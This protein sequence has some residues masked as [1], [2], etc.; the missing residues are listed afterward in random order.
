MIQILL[1][2]VFKSGIRL[3]ENSMKY[4]LIMF[5]KPCDVPRYRCSIA[6]RISFSVI[7]SSSSSNTVL[8]T[9]GPI[10]WITS[11]EFANPLTCSMEVSF[12]IIVCFGCACLVGGN[13]KGNTGSFVQAWKKY[14]IGNIAATN[15]VLLIRLHIT[16]SLSINLCFNGYPHPPP[17]DLDFL[18]EICPLSVSCLSWL[19]LLSLTFHIF[20][21]SRTAGSLFQPNMAQ[22][23][24]GWKEFKLCSNEGPWP[25]PRGYNSD[26]F[27]EPLY[28]PISTI[29]MVGDG[30][31]NSPASCKGPCPIPKDD[32]SNIVKIHWLWRVKRFENLE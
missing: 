5:S 27:P 2:K 22:S 19:S 28:E 13:C 20:V 25:Y 8:S 30:V 18:I 1:N 16:S 9:L 32:N 10:S 14:L 17:S 7:S 4:S 15:H 21:F 29:K 3:P 12:V 24:L 11:L 31:N 23:L 6:S 26:I